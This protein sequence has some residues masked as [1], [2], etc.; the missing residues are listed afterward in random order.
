[1]EVLLGGE[2]H[3]TPQEKID[4]WESTNA[5]RLARA[6]SALT[7]IFESGTLDLATLSVAARQVRSMVRGMGTRSEV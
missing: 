1:M 2:P 7:E 6:R 5:S 4:D 3:E